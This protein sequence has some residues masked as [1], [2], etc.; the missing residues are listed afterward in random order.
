MSEQGGHILVVDD[1]RVNRQLLRRALEQQE[2]SVVSAE[3]GLQAL[4]LVRSEA[5]DVVL[6]DIMMPEL[7]GY[8]VLKTLKAD[9]ELRRIPVI[10]ISAIDEMGSVIRCIEMGAADYLPK[11]FNAALLRARINASLADKRLHDMEQAYLAQIKAEQEK[12]EQLLL[13]IL[14]E[15][16]AERLKD[17]ETIIADSF[18]EV[19]VLFADLVGFT[20]FSAE[21]SPGEVVMLLDQVF[22]EFDRLADNHGLEKIKT[23]GDAYMAVSGLPES[24]IDHIEAA[25]EMAIDMRDTIIS[26]NPSMSFPLQTRIGLHSGPVVAGVIGRKKFIYDLWGNTVNIA[27]RMESH[28]V[29]DKIHVTDEVYQR[30]ARDYEFQELGDTEIKGKGRMKTY[31]LLERKIQ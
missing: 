2:H 12:S 3:H 15:S 29:S 4:E 20:S 14:P 28:G 13:S 25:A 19:T 21:S 18:P 30:L 5:F 24:R 26:L 16:I 22:T 11:P 1:N 8:D 9:P 27:S 6:L 23:I 17:S 10:M 31:I 7:N